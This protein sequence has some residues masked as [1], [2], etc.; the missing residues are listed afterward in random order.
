M[1][2]GRYVLPLAVLLVIIGKLE[3]NSRFNV[4]IHASNICAKAGQYVYLANR[5][6]IHLYIIVLLSR[7]QGGSILL[8]CKHTFTN[9]KLIENPS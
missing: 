1:E 5:I 8:P 3:L 2:D 7:T 9:N 4:H 6:V